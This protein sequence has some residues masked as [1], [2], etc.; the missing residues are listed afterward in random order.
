MTYRLLSFPSLAS[1][2]NCLSIRIL[3]V[4]YREGLERYRN[5][6]HERF[7]TRKGNIPLEASELRDKL[8]KLWS[9]ITNWDLIPLRYGYFEIFIQTIGRSEN[10]WSV[11]TSNISHVLHVYGWPFLAPL[12][13]EGGLMIL[14][15]STR[16]KYQVI[17]HLF[18]EYG[19][20]F[21]Y[22]IILTK[23]K[24]Y[25]GSSS[26]SRLR[27]IVDMLGFTIEQTTFNCL[28]VLILKS[29]SRTY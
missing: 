18:Q 20:N 17:N 25:V 11:R 15:L 13:F 21:Y 14:C 4:A 29:N 1:K 10:C 9:P 8:I 22:H 5:N 23:C 27:N 2:L 3:E 16:K 26:I 6:L 19:Q 12:F 28:G 7:I 24:I